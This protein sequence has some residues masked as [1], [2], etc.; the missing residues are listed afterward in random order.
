ME[1]KEENDNFKAEYLTKKCSQ[2][3]LSSLSAF[4][5]VPVERKNPK[6][7]SYFYQQCKEE[8]IPTYDSIFKRPRSYNEKLHRDDRTHS[9]H[10]SWNIHTEEISRP[11]PVLSS[12]EYGRHL[13]HHVDKVTRD[14]VRIGLIRLEF[15]RKNGMSKSVEESYGSV[16]PS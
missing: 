14:H 3:H 2:P 7:M 16:V 11:V 5:Q 12:S 13:Q 4:S 8:C 15:Y 9:K 1:V 10:H 6:R